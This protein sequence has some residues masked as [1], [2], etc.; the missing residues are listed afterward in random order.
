MV[1]AVATI[2]WTLGLARARQLDEKQKQLAGQPPGYLQHI[3][4]PELEP[5]S[6]LAEDGYHPGPR[7]YRAMAKAVAAQ[8][9]D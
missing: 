9:W 2:P 5:P 1:I 3:H 7:G 8:L 6:L 4:Y